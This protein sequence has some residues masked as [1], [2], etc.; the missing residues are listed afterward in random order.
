VSPIEAQ[1][2]MPAMASS[3]VLALADRVVSCRTAIAKNQTTIDVCWKNP[4]FEIAANAALVIRRLIASAALIFPNLA[5]G[6]SQFGHFSL[7][8]PSK[9]AYVFSKQEKYLPTPTTQNRGKP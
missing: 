8:A 1:R 5:T 9:Q 4:R 6:A 2:N 3:R 7:G